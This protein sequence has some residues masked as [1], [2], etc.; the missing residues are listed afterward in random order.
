[1]QETID[2]IIFVNGKRKVLPLGAG[3]KTLLQYLRGLGYT[4]AKLGCG[5]GGCGACTVM[6]SSI[7]SDGSLLHRSINACLCPLYA[8]EGQHVV[9]VE[10]IGSSRKGLHPVQ[11]RLANAHGSQCGFC[12][13]GFVMSMYSLL[14]SK[15]GKSISEEEIE[16]NLAGNLCRCTGYRPI[17]DAFRPF[18]KADPKAYTE[19]A[20]QAAAAESD[21]NCDGAG[22][23]QKKSNG[24][25]KGNTDG[26]PVC[27]S[28]GK[29]C[30]CTG[31]V[32]EDGLVVSSS[33][34]KEDGIIGALVPTEVVKTDKA[35]KFR[36]YSSSTAEPIFPPEL[37][38]RQPQELYI[39]GPVAAWYRPLTLR[40]LL[41]IKN[42][43]PDAKLI[44]GNSE[45]GIEMKFKNML[46]PV[47]IG[48]THVPE[49]NEIRAEESGIHFGASVTLTKLL[50]TCRQVASQEPPFRCG[51]LNAIAEQLRWFAGPPIR[52][53][54]SIGGNVCTASP[55]SDL[56]PLWIAAGA[57][58]TVASKAG[59]KRSIP[60]GAF[61]LGY[62]K[63]DLKPNEV[64]VSVFLPFTRKY[65]YVKEF[66]QAHRRDDDIAIVNAGMKFKLKPPSNTGSTSTVNGIVSLYRDVTS[67][68]TFEEV[69]IAYGGVAP[70]TISAPKTASALIGQPLDQSCLKAALTALS[71]DVNM[72]PNAP[73]GMVEF[74]RSLAASFLFKGVV[75]AATALEADAP[76]ESPF[77][78]PF[79]E[80]YRSAVQPYHRPSTCG[81][82]YYSPTS[83]VD[84]VGQPYRHAAADM[85]VTGEAIYVDDMPLPP[86][87]LHAAM[88]VSSKPHAKLIS[89]DTTPAVLLPGVA[90]IFCAKDIPGG[91]DIG[92][93]IHDEELFASELV[94]CV[95]QPIGVVVA[96]S[97]AEARAAA[98]AVVVEYEE[99]PAILDIE[100]AAA[101]NS[102]FEG[103]G[104]AIEC[105]DVDPTL[106]QCEENSNE[107]SAGTKFVSGE[108]RM[109]GQE[110]FYLEPNAHLVIPGE[111]DEIVSYSSTQCPDKHHRYIA[112]CLGIPM[113]KVVVRTKRLGGGFGGKETRAAFLNAAAAVP[114]Y[115]LK[116]PV[117]LVLD[118]D[119]DMS[120]TGHRHP[121]MAKYKVG[122]TPQGQFLA[123][124][125]DFY[126]NAGNSL[127]LSHS[128]MDRALMHCENCYNIP[129]LRATGYVCRTNMPSNTAFRGFGG[130]QGMIVTEEIV[131]RI[132]CLVK[133]LPEEIREL[134]FYKEG[135]LTPYGM[136]LEGFQARACWDGVAASAGGMAARRVSIAEYNAKNRFRK[137]GIAAIPT[138]FGIS[139]TTKFLNQAGAL[140]HI[141]QADG[142]V[143]VTHGGVEMGQG[144]HTKVCQIVAQSLGIPLSS[145]HIA[146]TAT[147]KVPNASP[148]AASA[149]S[150][151][152][153]AAAADACAQLN[154]RLAPYKAKLPP[155]S[156]FVEIV[157]AAYFDRTDLSAHGF[158]STP[159]ITGF[160][161]NRPVNY[162]TFG[163][164]V[165][166]VELDT[167]TGDWQILRADVVMDVGKS[168]NPAIDVGQVEGAFVQG[169]GWSCIEE[170]VWGDNQHQWVKPGTL[171]TRGPGSYKI[172]TANDIPIDLRVTL[173]R[174]SPCERTPMV[175]SS[176]AVGEP[177]F[178]LGTTVYWALKDAVYSARKD[179]GIEG[180]FRLD[181][182]CTPERL[183]MACVDEFT[184]PYGGADVVPKLSC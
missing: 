131:D 38:S 145:V 21:K 70:L 10:G 173:L 35:L 17:L 159:D 6:V 84:V 62:R 78:L 48:A 85:Q 127:D 4:G 108:V 86:K 51:A 179:V 91:N 92:A 89:V 14:R 167:L 54:A 163:A 47:L 124:N 112:H 109:G 180:F 141:Y 113:H 11:E 143:L 110:H 174:D 75:Y 153:G 25:D 150:D 12:T 13:P 56:N 184:A 58:F 138:K 160:G 125:I 81:L 136:K 33:A 55:I 129:H 72:S 101:E 155:N 30:T 128:I 149:S 9:T 166:E 123:I 95:G 99:L 115:I 116:R 52:N 34:D 147:D 154:A 117:R 140:V 96:E 26:G 90:G 20:L 94:T 87:T 29:P 59:G 156:T 98:R 151:M 144:L 157:Q 66:K 111:D 74:R 49:L 82:Q 152:Y 135:D 3:E 97:E 130:P 43:N 71:E 61:F 2:P 119:E 27:P 19:D 139:F 162:F 161:G 170:L 164:A 63:V 104:H 64:L 107:S 41:E 42:E 132:A 148:T 134:N 158:Y 182:P 16:E 46:Y 24:H 183:R 50:T 118:R 126:N 122:C 60:A 57:Q 68:W 80:S 69:T 23:V 102:F 171:F 168:L 114:A 88:I 133:K 79:E 137:R 146:E 45:V 1:M 106:L 28:T 175:H 77:E 100:T 53:G 67:N 177:P 5:E 40:K 65:E 121:Y 181:L 22:S 8:V 39:P 172:P 36:N 31:S 7:D 18:A 15:N 44:V 169:M 37:R 176:K 73:G 105:G 32:A 178:F 93:V 142:S 165:A 76:S 103:W 120:M 83:D